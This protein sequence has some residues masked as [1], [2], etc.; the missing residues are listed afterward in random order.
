MQQNMMPH[1]FPSHG[2]RVIS[3]GALATYSQPRLKNRRFAKWTM[4]LD[5]S[6]CRVTASI[7]EFM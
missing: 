3:L 7:L 4:D 2:I 1:H 6:S 5:P